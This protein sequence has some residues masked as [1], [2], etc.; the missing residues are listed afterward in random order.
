MKYWGIVLFAALLEVVWVIGLKHSDVWWQ[1]LITLAAVVYTFK[2]L[3]DAGNHL[4][5]GTLYAVF[6][7]LGTAGTVISDI[8]LFDAPIEAVK[9]ILIAVLLIGVIGLKLVTPDKEVSS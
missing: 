8:I 1:W 5:V 3:L 9:I 2:L 6:V 7:G 4:P